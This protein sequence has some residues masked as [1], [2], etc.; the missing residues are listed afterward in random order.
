MHVRSSHLSELRAP[1]IM[2]TSLK[3]LP[4]SHASS[5]SL[6]GALYRGMK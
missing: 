6:Q 4:L 3:G 2:G 5:G 1:T